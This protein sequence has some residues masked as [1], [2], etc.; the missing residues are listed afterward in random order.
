MRGVSQTM[1]LVDEVDRLKPLPE[2]C[3]PDKR[4][5]AFVVMHT[6]TGVIRPR[7]LEDHYAAIQ[8][9]SLSEFVPKD[10]KTHFET[11]RNLLLYSWFVFRFNSVAEMQAYVSVEFA[12]RERI[13]NAAG[14]NPGMKRLLDYAIKSGLIKVKAFRTISI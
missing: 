3:N 11:A 2:V 4:Q 7:T 10:I 6:I 1:N 14:K 8:K 9:F 5:Q 12:L 13:G